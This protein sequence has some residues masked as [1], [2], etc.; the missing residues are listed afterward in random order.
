[1][2]RL[3]NQKLEVGMPIDLDLIDPDTNRHVSGFIESFEYGVGE[4]GLSIL[5]KARIGTEYWELVFPC[6]AKIME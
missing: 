2:A 4:A 1:M 6:E 5:I 3:F